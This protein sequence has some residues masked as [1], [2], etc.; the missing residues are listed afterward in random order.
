MKHN[1]H[2]LIILFAIMFAAT[3]AKAQNADKL[4][5]EEGLFNHLSVGLSTASMWLC[6]S[7]RQ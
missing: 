7:T 6:L 1:I 5:A 4:H 3:G 2:R